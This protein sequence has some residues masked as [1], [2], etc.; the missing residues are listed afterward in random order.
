MFAKE[1]GI[2]PLSVTPCSFFILLSIISIALFVGW[3]LFFFFFFFFFRQEAVA[4][5][6]S[7]IQIEE[8]KTESATAK[9][10]HD[11]EVRIKDGKLGNFMMCQCV[12][13][14]VSVCVSVCYCVCMCL[15]VCVCVC[16]RE[17]ERERERERLKLR[18]TMR[19]F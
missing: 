13:V 14:C 1:W 6:F 17:R 9:A 5:F 3:L 10:T 12:C 11:A 15:C 18:W 16:V 8:L 4:Y 2:S 7:L 19:K